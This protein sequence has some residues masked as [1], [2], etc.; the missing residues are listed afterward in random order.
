ML[1]VLCNVHS[2]TYSEMKSFCTKMAETPQSFHSMWW[3]AQSSR[4]S[5]TPVHIWPQVDR[6]RGVPSL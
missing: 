4:M 3:W 6:L 2:A 5:R 1:S